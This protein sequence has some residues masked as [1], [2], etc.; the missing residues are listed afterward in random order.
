LA[1]ARMADSV[2]PWQRQMYMRGMVLRSHW[3]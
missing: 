3:K 2:T 1:A